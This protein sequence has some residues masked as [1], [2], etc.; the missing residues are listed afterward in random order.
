MRMAALGFLFGTALLQQMAGLP[1]WQWSLL[2]LLAVPLGVKYRHVRGPAFAVAG[3]L[4][5]SAMGHWMLQGGLDAALD[6]RD[7]VMEGRIASLPEIDAEQVRFHFS[8]AHL[9]LDGEAVAS[10][11]KILIS[12]Y[13]NAPPLRVGEH[14]R[15]RVR[16][17][18][19]YGFM[20][21]GGFDYEGWLFSQGIR[22]KGY[23]RKAEG[24]DA[25]TQNL[26]LDEGD[27]GAY[28]VDRLRQSLRDA[29]N[30]ALSGR[31]LGGLVTALAVGDRQGISDRQWNVLMRTGTNHLMAISGLHVGL[32][33]GLA[34]FLGRWLW[35]R[36]AYAAMRWPAPKAGAL[37]ALMAATVYALLAGFSVPTQRALVMI[38]VAMLA[39][40]AQKRIR[41]GSVLALALLLVLAW[42][43]LAVLAPGFWLSFGAV[44]V[45][46][47]GMSGRI[48]L[49]G[50]WWK[51]GRVQWLV[52]I[53]LLPLMLWLFQKASVVAPVANL[54]AVPWV[55]LVTV[56]LTLLGA[57]LVTP[58]PL[59]GK[60]M[61]VLAAW[62]L[63]AVW[64]VL[65]WLGDLSFAQWSQPAPP[66]WAIF[67]AVIGVVWWLLP[68]GWP[69]RWLGAVW[70]LPLILVRPQ[71][72]P[73]AQADFTLL[74][75]GQGLAAV[76]ETR[77]HVLVFDTGPRFRSGFNTGAAVLAPFLRA[78]GIS[79]VDLL[80]VSHGDND[81]RGGVG[82][83]LA[84]FP[85]TRVLSSVPE[86]LDGVNAE[87]CVA[88][89]TW[90]WDG[91]RIAML[92]PGREAFAGDAK[93]N[94]R[95]CVLRVDAGEGGAL[96]TGDIEREAERY[97]VDTFP[98]S[99][100]ADVLV[101]PHHGSLTSS[102]EA[103]I[104]TVAPGVALFPVGYA[105]RYGFP[106]PAVVAR[107]DE[108]GI[109]RL[110]SARHGAIR[111]RLG[112]EPA[113]QLA[114]TY[115][116]ASARYWTSLAR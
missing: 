40:L 98:A 13:N 84:E 64:I 95:S 116:Q 30:L 22:A 28:M 74:D 61:L 16:L 110:D 43:P 81:H 86:L 79:R 15:L 60:A 115:R 59:L 8:P 48:G 45:I 82:G 20:N 58:L 52:A 88:G 65:A 25:A 24:Q 70:L 7:V 29:M 14:W 78:R 21:P 5:A 50:F 55:S 108:R 3:F 17:K 111:F 9:Q 53:G 1:A 107:Y 101:V 75:V 105:N 112:A 27:N 4:W 47:L 66:L 104:D 94:N 26:R 6:G 38:A 23:V 2:L 80:V 32:V 90:Q 69:A 11:G 44:A 106:K 19:P 87:P 114:E 83:L 92:H 63:D 37:A 51:W 41:P 36:R 73:E 99:L 10:P 68:R 31:E 12:W 85:V 62:S 97:L 109:T 77:G 102:S 33:A 34:F 35:S 72:L 49:P 100:P 113:V 91:V 18:R 57:L 46:L 56:P 103:F 93:E 42:D 67:A 54:I 96:L 89:E 71:L 76:V 39:V